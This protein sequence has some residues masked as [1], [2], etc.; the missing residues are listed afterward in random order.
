MRRRVS[1]SSGRGR[2][3]WLLPPL[4]LAAFLLG[5]F[6]FA[7]T[8][9]RAAQEP[10]RVTDGI[11]VLTGG[12]GRIDRGFELLEAGLSERLF[13]SGVYRGVEVDELLDLAQRSPEELRCCIELG[14]EADDTLGNAYETE[15]WVAREG[16][17]DLRLVTAAYHMP[18]ARLELSRRL[19]G[20]E[21]LLEPVFTEGFREGD[22]WRR[23]NSAGLLALEYLKYLAAL[24]R[25][26]VTVLAELAGAGGSGS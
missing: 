11:V 23:R 22:W 2:L 13:I 10:D 14:Y 21:I 6:R 19:P 25:A 5:L 26:R 12:A 15:A 9:P 7:E 17:A 8:L 3:L 24:L 18:R 1:S 4:A 16:I 20:V